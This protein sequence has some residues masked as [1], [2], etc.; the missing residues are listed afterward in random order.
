M[1]TAKYGEHLTTE[2]TFKNMIPLVTCYK[3]DYET[4]NPPNCDVINR[5]DHNTQ[6]SEE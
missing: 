6:A 5:L 4:R 2:L 3:N 1:V